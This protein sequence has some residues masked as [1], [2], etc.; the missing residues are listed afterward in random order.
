MKHYKSSI[1]LLSPGFK[2]LL[3]QI[4]MLWISFYFEVVPLQSPPKS[5]VCYRSWPGLTFKK[6]LIAIQNRNVILFVKL[7]VSINLI[8]CRKFLFKRLTY[9]KVVWSLRAVNFMSAC[10]ILDRVN[11]IRP[12][13]RYSPLVFASWILRHYL[14]NIVVHHPLPFLVLLGSP[15]QS[16]CQWY[17]ELWDPLLSGFDSLTDDQSV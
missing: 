10:S 7:K 2:L 17:T 11:L 1:Q 13:L 5:L 6:S 16:R 4:E 3:A 14:I 12:I 9:N 8:E 15:I